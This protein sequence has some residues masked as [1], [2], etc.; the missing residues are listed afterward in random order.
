MEGATVGL[1]MAP[2][3]TFKLALVQ[4]PDVV[5]CRCDSLPRDRPIET[6]AVI[7]RQHSR[8]NRS[9]GEISTCLGG[10]KLFYCGRVAEMRPL[11]G[12]ITRFGGGHTCGKSSLVRRSPLHASPGQRPRP[13]S[14]WNMAIQPRVRAAGAGRAVT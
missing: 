2:D 10:E 13:A 14:S 11:Q 4:T 9:D 3:A 12:L 6:G 8:D 7:E 5:V 1:R